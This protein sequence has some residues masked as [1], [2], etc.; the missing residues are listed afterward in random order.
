MTEGEPMDSERRRA[1]WEADTVVP[2]LVDRIE[3][4][5]E[6]ISLLRERLE[7][8]TKEREQLETD[9]VIAERWVAA[10]ARELELADAQLQELRPLYS[11]IGSPMRPID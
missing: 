6:Q 9:L 5:E 7:A 11:R 2:E 1:V 3:Y 10:L 4:Q 8:V